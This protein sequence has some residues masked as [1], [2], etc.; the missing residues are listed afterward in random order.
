MNEGKFYD[1]KN[2]P[3]VRNNGEVDHTP[4]RRGINW[5]KKKSAFKLRKRRQSFRV[6]IIPAIIGYLERGIRKLINYLN[7]LSEGETLTDV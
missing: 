2:Q 7:K 5:D 6:K 3:H 1:K 4:D